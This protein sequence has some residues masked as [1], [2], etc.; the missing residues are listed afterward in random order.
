MEKIEYNIVVNSNQ[1]ESQVKSLNTEVGK[2][3]VATG[4]AGGNLSKGFAGL[5][6]A[7]G[8]VIP[9]FGRLR[10]AIASTGIGLIV[11]AAGALVSL[12]TSVGKKASEFS[13]ALSNLESITGASASEMGELT[14]QATELGSTTAFTA[15]QVV[16]LQTSL[17]KLGFK[18]D[19][20][21]KATESILNLGAALGVG[22]G[23]AA[24]V[25]GS[26]VR[27]FGLTT[28][29]T[30]RVVDVMTKAA[31]SSALSFDTIRESM[32]LVAPVSRATGVSIEKTSAL[33]G[34]LADNGLKGSIAGTGLAKSFIE[35]S[36]QGISLEEGMKAVN[37]SAEPLNTA[38]DL[39]GVVAGRTFLTLAAGADDLGGL[40]QAMNDAAGTAERM[41]AIQLDNVS[42]D[43]TKL[44]SA[45]E[46]LLL[47]IDKGDGIYLRCLE[48]LFKQVHLC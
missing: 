12:F 25:A 38:I 20:I 45:W 17:S 31:S 32:K 16:E 7:I 19:D 2:T 40:E 14:D 48:H 34:I 8:S 22:L 10:A 3:T 23:E 13:S 27:S 35:L 26:L 44:G 42:G 41:A 29:D 24:E 43:V 18:T 28:E 39:V 11:V 4:A 36:R 21:K 5:G 1:A 37:D 33:L 15:S 30:A 9:M 6:G 47:S 46:G